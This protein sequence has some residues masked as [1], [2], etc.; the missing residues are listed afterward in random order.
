[1]DKDVTPLPHFPLHSPMTNPPSLSSSSSHFTAVNTPVPCVGS[2]RQRGVSPVPDHSAVLTCLSRDIF[3]FLFPPPPDLLNS[4]QRGALIVTGGN[5]RHPARGTDELSS[6]G[7]DDA[8]V[9]YGRDT[10]KIHGFLIWWRRTAGR[11]LFIMPVECP[12]G[13]GVPAG[14][15][16]SGSGRREQV[17]CRTSKT[18]SISSGACF[19]QAPGIQFILMELLRRE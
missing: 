10:L 7:V 13:G 1:M 9:I 18:Y 19:H 17:C 5:R 16:R 14:A 12:G 6:D 8:A 3:F 15:R 2:R 11:M 4:A